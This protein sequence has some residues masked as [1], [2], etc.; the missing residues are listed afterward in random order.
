VEATE[1]VGTLY[2]KSSIKPQGAGIVVSEKATNTFEIQIQPG[3]KYQI[4]YQAI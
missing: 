1:G 3:K 2:L 4:I